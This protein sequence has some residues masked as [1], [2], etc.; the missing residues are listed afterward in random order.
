MYFL[1]ILMLFVA[2]IMLNAY[3][4]TKIIEYKDGNDKQ[5]KEEIKVQN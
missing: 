2:N 1:M 3:I 4:T 5:T